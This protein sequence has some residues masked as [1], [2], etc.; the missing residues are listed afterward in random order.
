MW[1]NV[2]IL[3]FASL[4]FGFILGWIAAR[5]RRWDWHA[6]GPAAVSVRNEDVKPL[7]PR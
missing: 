7:V 1:L 4:V 6:G 3:G 5:P 2:V